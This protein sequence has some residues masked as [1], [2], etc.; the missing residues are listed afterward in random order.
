MKK[1]FLTKALS[2]VMAAALLTGGGG[3]GGNDKASS[4][5]SIIYDISN[6]IFAN[7]WRMFESTF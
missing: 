3:G 4:G 5:G 7:T 2:V 6:A 1:K